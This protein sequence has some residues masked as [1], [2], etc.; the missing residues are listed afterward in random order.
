MSTFLLFSWLASTLGVR[1][2]PQQK[3]AHAKI[4]QL[5]CLSY[6]PFRRKY[7]QPAPDDEISEAQL[8]SDL[9]LLSSYTKCIRIYASG[10]AHSKI[11][12][13]ANSL[14]IGVFLG[15]YLSDDEES[16]KQEIEQLLALDKANTN[17]LGLIVGNEV[18]LRNYY[19]VEKT[20]SME[21]LAQTIRYVKSQTSTKV[22][23]SDAFN[24]WLWYPQLAEDVDFISVHM[25]PFWGGQFIRNSFRW[26]RANY[27]TMLEKFPGIP[28]FVSEIGWPSI[29]AP[30]K[31]AKASQKN[32]TSFYL[33]FAKKMK[34]A[35][36]PLL[37]GP[38]F[39]FMEAFDQPWKVQES[40]GRVGAHWGIFDASASPK[41]PLTDST[42]PRPIAWTIGSIFLLLFLLV[43]LSF[44]KLGSFGKLRTQIW[45]A[46]SLEISFAVSA[47]TLIVAWQEYM[48][49]I[50][51]IFAMLGLILINIVIG[52]DT[53]LSAKIIEHPTPEQNV[54]G[55]A[56]GI[57][58]PRILPFV[59]IHV[60]CAN[61]DPHHL[62][63][64]LQSLQS[65]DYPH[66]EVI[67]AVNNTDN[68]SLTE[69]IKEFCEQNNNLFVYR[70]FG[71]I[72]GFKSGALN[73]CLEISNSKAEFIA[74]VD[75]DYIVQPRWL[76]ACMAEFETSDA[77]SVQCPQAYRGFE[78]SNVLR[79]MRDELQGFF[80]I[81]MVDRALVNSVV[82]HGTMLVVRKEE[83]LKL[84]GWSE[85]SICEDAALGLEILKK[86]G[87]I[88]YIHHE[89]GLGL[90]PTSQHAYA[91]QRFRWVYGGI[92]IIKK[93]WREFL[94]KSKNLTSAQ[95]FHFFWGWFPW[96]ADATY[97]PFFVLSL[98]IAYFIATK[99]HFMP[100]PVFTLPLLILVMHKIVSVML[101][102][103]IRVKIG[104]WRTLG[105]IV[106]GVS[107]TTVVSAAAIAAI[108]GLKAGFTSTQK[109]SVVPTA[110]VP[111][112]WNLFLWRSYRQGADIWLC[113][114]LTGCGL[115]AWY[116]SHCN[117]ES[118]LWLL[119]FIVLSAP[120]WARFG[121][122]LRGFSS[123]PQ[124]PL[125]T[126]TTL[127]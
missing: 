78:N 52:L 74:L 33:D 1:T 7:T 18:A 40:E 54:A 2:Q 126:S 56:I 15:A 67:V 13:I 27:E 114:L 108:F 53:F 100:S 76:M 93:N 105:A 113:L 26:V 97:I 94:P 19:K 63:A 77:T 22:S 91:R 49:S 4:N 85:T 25:I 62:L 116:R 69:P 45:I 46:Y 102:Y 103:N 48:L 66:Y 30:Y 70:N 42:N 14:G 82:Q 83:L 65:L 35:D 47:L 124:L 36:W 24:I 88:S 98:P 64:C 81:G 106:A 28:I 55:R 71:M 96:I 10:G 39:N 99:P 109:S 73:R 43:Y 11:P 9:T 92:E 123:Q 110:V 3:Y 38:G 79:A 119:Y 29:G 6:N 41:I 80:D 84:N 121:L 104:F 120:G 59:S 8:R 58:E 87:R 127:P 37:F 23:Y 89:L 57:T 60:P 32:Q 72:S 51:S 122:M 125:K 17:I 90:L 112:K 34:S 86:G 68:P 95:K 101:T 20:I 16:N 107:L 50:Y 118:S 12:A 61:E 115:V 21:G 117:L 75:A 111:A 5:P 31:N 44:I